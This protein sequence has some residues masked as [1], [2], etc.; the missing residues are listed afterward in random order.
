MSTNRTDLPRLQ[1]ERAARPGRTGGHG[2]RDGRRRQS[3]LG[4]RRGPP[5][6]RRV[7]RARRQ[8]AASASAG[9]ASRSCSPAAAPRPT[10]RR[11]RRSPR[12]PSG[13]G[14]PRWS[15]RPPLEHPSLKGAVAVAS[16]G[17]HGRSLPGRTEPVGLVAAALV[18]HELGTI[19]DAA[20]LPRRCARPP[21]RVQ[22]AGK[23]SR[24]QRRRLAR[25]Q[26][27]QARRAAGRRRA[28][29]RRSTTGC[30][31]I[32]A[33]GHQERG[34]AAR[35]RERRSAS[36]VSAR[37]RPRSTS[38]PWPRVAALGERLEA[39]ILA[40]PG[41]R[42]PRRRLAR[43]SAARIN[44]GF[45]GARGQDLVIAL[46]LAGIAASTGAACTSGS[47]KPSRVLLGLGLTPEQAAR[48]GAVLAR[49][50]HDA[51]RDRRGPAHACRL[52]ERARLHR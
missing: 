4:P 1:R 11:A 51:E 2:R 31:A 34:R 20:T 44:A 16:A 33:A 45:A 5:D 19:L 21:R 9:R 39:G 29:A 7:E 48:G 36:S 27:A 43:A 50:H 30:R 3:V 23:L 22:A 28:R 17:Q 8:V 47:V 49:P 12:R 35:H 40:H 52:V 25:D 13:A 24:C 26:R 10:A 46:D 14:L 32:E 41:A 37:P 42:D 15:R 6:A 38:P 18:N